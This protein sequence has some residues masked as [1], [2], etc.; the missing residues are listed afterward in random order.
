MYIQQQLYNRCHHIVGANIDHSIEWRGHCGRRGPAWERPLHYFSSGAFSR[1]GH[2]KMV[3]W[4]LPFSYV[5]F[6]VLM[7]ILKSK[8]YHTQLCPVL[9]VLAVKNC[10]VYLTIH[11][12]NNCPVLNRLSTCCPPQLCCLVLSFHCKSEWSMIFHYQLVKRWS[13]G[14]DFNCRFVTLSARKL[15]AA[16]LLN[17]YFQIFL[18]L[19]MRVEQ[20]WLQFKV[21]RRRENR[22]CP[23][24][25]TYSFS[26]CFLDQVRSVSLNSLR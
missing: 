19:Q 9:L 1:G 7:R 23:I 16:V 3:K 8:Q 18:K 24:K 10:P 6:T 22:F 15:Q 2:S 11:H 5:H 20:L 14:G 4:L 17:V 13:G 12:S 21:H 25:S 26:N